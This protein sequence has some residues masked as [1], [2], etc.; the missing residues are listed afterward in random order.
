MLAARLLG[1]AVA[2]EATEVAR[3]VGQGLVALAAMQATA[4][5]EAQL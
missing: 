4:A 1:M 3:L 5:T 2:T